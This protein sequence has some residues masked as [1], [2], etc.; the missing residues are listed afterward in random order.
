MPLQR[1]RAAH[2]GLGRGPVPLRLDLLQ[3]LRQFVQRIEVTQYLG[4]DGKNRITSWRFV[5]DE[6]VS[7][8]Q[9]LRYDE[10]ALLYQA[11]HQKNTTPSSDLP[12][13]KTTE[14]INDPASMDSNRKKVDSSKG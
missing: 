10:L 5:D 8:G 1:G 4:I 9:W 13:Q 7:P 2:E 3:I 6:D 14:P 12:V 11:M